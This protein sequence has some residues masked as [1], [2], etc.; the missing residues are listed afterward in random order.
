M[1][2]SS[3]TP[4]RLEHAISCYPVLS[5]VASYISTV[6]LLNLAMTSRANHSFILGSRASF[7][8]LRRDCLCDGRSLRRR[9][10]MPGWPR[11]HYDK[12]PRTYTVREDEEIEVR[13]FNIKCDE[14]GA[15]PCRKC[16]INICE[17]C[18]HFPRLPTQNQQ[19]HDRRPHLHYTGEKYNVMALC[20][21]CD[22]ATEE[23]LRG[24]F[25]NELCDCDVFR[26]WMCLGCVNQERDEASEYH[27]K[28]T[29]HK[30]GNEDDDYDSDDNNLFAKEISGKGKLAYSPGWHNND[31]ERWFHCPCGGDVP[32]DAV[33]RCSWCKR[34]HLPESEWWRDLSSTFPPNT[35]EDPCYPYW[36]TDGHGNYPTPYP[37]LRYSEMMRDQEQQQLEPASILYCQYLVRNI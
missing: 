23:Q 31:D 4:S 13:V 24:N 30:A 36:T 2:N 34:R 35:D 1:A 32:Q 10:M 3:P 9:Q 33:F 28:Y 27:Q 21:A 17:E 29:R 26:R 25:L 14:T 19:S 8:V 15:L 11:E 7:D 6:D 16:G 18:R 22:N 12:R 5:T 20:L 37:P